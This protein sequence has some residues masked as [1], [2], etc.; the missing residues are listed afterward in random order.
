MVRIM[1]GKYIVAMEHA[2]KRGWE[3]D[4]W[5]YIA[6]PDDLYGL[7]NGAEI[8]LLHGWYENP[9]AETFTDFARGGRLKGKYA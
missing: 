8:L 2:R 5:A 6:K 1:A 4:D 7:E 9:A 3:R